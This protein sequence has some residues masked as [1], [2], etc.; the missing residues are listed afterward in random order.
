MSVFAFLANLSQLFA[1]FDCFGLTYHTIN[2]AVN[3]ED[4]E[5]K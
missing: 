3:C 1:N 4:A 5:A 2:Q